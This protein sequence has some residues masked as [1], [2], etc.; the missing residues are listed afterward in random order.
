MGAALWRGV[1]AT[2]APTP[3]QPACAKS[4]GCRY[5]IEVFGQ[6]RAPWRA[7]PAEAMADAVRLD[8]TSWDESR[9]EHYLAVPVDMRVRYPEPS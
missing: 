4:P 7:S 3:E 8:L 2:I 9:Q 5:R 1:A 6:P